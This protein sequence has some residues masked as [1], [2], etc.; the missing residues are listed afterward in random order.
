[1][2]HC[3]WIFPAFLA[4]LLLVGCSRTPEEIQPPPTEAPLTTTVMV[5]MVGS[6]L[7]AKAGS[8][9]KD[10]EEMAASGVDTSLVNL[11][12]YAGGSPHWHNEV[13]SPEE[14]RVLTLGAEGFRCVNT[15]PV[16][17]MGESPCLASFLNYVYTN[18]PADRYALILWDHGDGPVIGYGRDMLFGND[19]L[20]LSEMRQA[21]E[22]S[23]FGEGNK[24]A[25]VG[26]DACLMA[27]AELCCVWAPYADYLVASQEVEPSFGWDYRFLGSTSA[28]DTPTLL[29]QLTQT[30]LDTCLAYY[31]SRGYDHRD[32]TLSC[33]DL[34][35]AGELN[36]AIDALF[37]L[38]AQDTS[39]GYNDLASR[40]VQTRALGRA[41]TGSEYDLIDLQDMARQ[42]SDLYPD[43][44]ARLQTVID[45]M[46]IS[47]S[48][49]AEGCSGLSLYYPFYNKAYYTNSWRQVYTQLD[50]FPNYL[51]YLERYQDTWLNSD[52]LDSFATSE[53]PSTNSQNQY[54]LQLTQ[55][56]AEAYASASYYI[57]RREGHE[58]YSRI[59]SSQ[60]VSLD[61]T[62]LTANYDGDILYVRN[63]FGQWAIPNSLEH[64]TSGEVTR[65]SVPVNLSNAPSFSYMSHLED[66]QQVTESYRFQLAVDTDTKKI[67]VSAL[68]PWDEDPSAETLSGGKLDDVDL[69]QWTNYVFV[70]QRNRYL[71]RYENGVIQPVSTW[72][73]NGW[74]S[75]YSYPIGDGAEFFFAPLVAGEYYLLFEIE[76][77]QG[78]RYCSE[79]LPIQADG[80]EPE[81]WQPAPIEA[82]FSS[83]D[84]VLLTQQAG[85]DI[86]MILYDFYDE[87]KYS[88]EIVN[89]N[90]FPVYV[91]GT[92]MIVNGDT[93]CT[94]GSMGYHI[95]EP[96]ET[97]TQSPIHFG[98]LQDLFFPEGLSS[99]RF[100][101]NAENALTQTS[102]VFDQVFSVTLH[103]QMQLQPSAFSYNY[104]AYTQPSRSI[105]AQEQVLKETDEM[106]ISLLGLGGNPESTGIFGA[107]C[108]ENR[109]DQPIY[110]G[111]GGVVL[112]GIRLNPSTATT[113]IPANSKIYTQ[114]AVLEDDL[115][116]VG[117]S[118]AG[119]VSLLM[120]VKHAVSVSGGGG[121]A[122][123]FMLP[124]QLSQSGT[125]AQVGANGNVLFQ[126]D[127]VKVTFLRQSAV[128]GGYAW[129]VLVE[130]TSDRFISLNLTGEVIN[131][132]VLEESEYAGQGI[133][134]TELGPN[135]KCIA[136]ISY[137]YEQT[138]PFDSMAF[139]FQILDYNGETILYTGKKDV[140]LRLDP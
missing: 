17:S 39:A 109:T 1:M 73:H 79:L 81:V 53:E 119:S 76:D 105:L 84:R 125:P 19:S 8:A 71:T 13:A 11:V 112:D 83:G 122:Q 89:H 103:S 63:K 10:L 24:L 14:H 135:Q 5:Y 21:L 45:A 114:I 106:R 131:G 102:I 133:F 46:V 118:S 111:L 54:I 15:Q 91:S 25:W 6:D 136:Y 12:V 67:S 92:D 124:V 82:D 75:Y 123:Q 43:A 36:A 78:N 99:L 128:S 70:N 28:A 139:R 48:T 27:S 110:V 93:Y 23:P 120:Q 68:T 41:S 44:A 31:E 9:T 98:R 97:S 4:L 129:Y 104:Y 29:T 40:R 33:L 85:L 34:S 26:F 127:G 57:L 138:L 134:D 113:E 55:Q 58:L 60:D 90:D 37:A 42:L 32:T 61:G 117:L 101:L 77:T 22:D 88:L 2:K 50:L 126:E 116:A 20:T 7:E 115:D 130:N 49:N 140:T 66:F 108:I 132:R 121:F 65:Y 62:T 137:L 35:Q 30:Y 96:G 38:A 74:I 51:T 52:F 94:M 18:F 95:I 80:P 56:Q 47:N 86:Y 72:P 87:N 16:S 100:T 3:K 69:S 64:D 59:F 107:L